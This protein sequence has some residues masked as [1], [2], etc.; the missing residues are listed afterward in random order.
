[1]KRIAFAIAASL[2]LGGSALAAERAAAPKPLCESFDVL[3]A[4]LAKDKD[5]AAVKFTPLSPGEF[6][7]V[8]GVYAASPF[9][10]PGPPP[11]DGAQLMQV[12]GKS[13]VVWTRGK[14]ACLSLIATGE[15]NEHGQP[16]VAYMPMP[17]S[18]D[19]L[20]ALVSIKTGADESF[21]VPE[22]TSKDMSL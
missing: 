1:M 17:L 13:A 7:F 3:K 8:V 9:T 16:V 6:H 22:D 4:D 10:P 15:K 19:L 2:A 14:T 12:G 18:V 20:K 21:A 11:G 5:S